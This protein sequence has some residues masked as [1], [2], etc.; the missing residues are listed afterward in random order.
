MNLTNVEYEDEQKAV[1]EGRFVQLKGWHDQHA[2]PMVLIFEACKI[3]CDFLQKDTQNVVAVH[4]EHGKGRTGTIIASYLM[5]CGF[6]DS[7][8]NAL[9]YFKQKRYYKFHS[10]LKHTC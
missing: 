3:I 2:P 8:E 1:F 9:V 10:G 7:A 4:C 5:Y 6:A